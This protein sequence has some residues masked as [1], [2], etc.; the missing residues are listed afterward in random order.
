MAV[1]FGKIE[2]LALEFYDSSSEVLKGAVFSVMAFNI[3]I[4]LFLVPS[5]VPLIPQKPYDPRANH[6]P[7]DV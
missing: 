4:C 3:F 1:R 2:A 7:I 6:S 5:L